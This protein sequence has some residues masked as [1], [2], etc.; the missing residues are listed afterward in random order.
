MF[1]MA[2]PADAVKVF[3]CIQIKKIIWCNIKYKTN[4]VVKLTGQYQN[5]EGGE[6]KYHIK[7][8]KQNNRQECSG[9]HLKVAFVHCEIFM[10]MKK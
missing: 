4:K 10:E 3:F 9:I 2:K 7:L 1:H 6:N 5:I 8:F